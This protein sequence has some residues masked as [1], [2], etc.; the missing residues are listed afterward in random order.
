MESRS[1]GAEKQVLINAVNERAGA[2]AFLD[3]VST[4]PGTCDILQRFQHD[5]AHSG[6]RK[7]K[8]ASGG[9]DQTGRTNRIWNPEE[10]S[11]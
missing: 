9:V 7:G 2:F 8:I 6:V 3:P 11:R 4:E 5:A 1:S 10:H